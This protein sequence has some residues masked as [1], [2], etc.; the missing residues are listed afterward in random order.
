MLDVMRRSKGFT[1]II[2]GLV[3]LATAGS[4]ALAMYGLWGGGL[5]GKEQGAPDWIANVDGE[6]I[7]TIVFQ[8]TRSAIENDMRQR[9]AGQASDEALASYV[10]QQALGSVLGQYL[11]EREAE[12]AGLRVTAAEISS[13]IVNSP[14]WQKDGRFV[15]VQAYRKILEMNRIKVAEFERERQKELAAEKLRSAVYALARVDDAEVDRRFRDEVERVDV[16]YVLLADTAFADAKPAAPAEVRSWYSSHAS[17]FTTPEARR[18]VY[19]LFDRESKAASLPVSDAEIKDAYEKGKTTTYS[20]P[21]QRRASHI[22]IKVPQ[23]APPEKDAEIKAKAAALLAR[24]RAGED[25]ATLA[26]Q[27]SEDPGSAAAGGDLG[28]F[29][30]NRMVKEFEDAAFSLSVGAVSDVVKSPFGYHIIK[31]TEA[32]PAGVQPLDEVK[33]EIRRSLVVTKAQEEVRKSAEEFERKLAAQESSFDKSASALGYKLADTGYFEKGSPAGPLGRLPQVEDA[34]F[35]LKPGGVSA[36]VTVPQGLAVFSLAE[37]RA[38]RP[39]PFDNVKEKVETEL[40]KSR[41]RDKARSIAGEIVAAKGDLKGRVEKRKL[42]VKS[43]PQVTRAQSLPPLTDASK[44]AA[45]AAPIGA[46][47]GPYE[48][49]DG[50]LVIAVKGKSPATSD[51]A[52]SERASL[53]R[54]MLDEERNTLY[55]AFLSR[56]EKTSQIEINE[57]LLRRTRGQS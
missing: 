2:F 12:R 3:V 22:L 42:E 39:A 44:A 26:R 37:V 46:V 5:S 41:A 54:R 15:G 55:Q 28:F 45:F 6:P 30:R 36:P 38:P 50:L 40:K 33:A 57:G 19:I 56:V 32:R 16:E 52:V 11:S 21:D 49:D 13:D 47:L 14:T 23:D 20:H 53:R 18:A 25:F 31:V 27:N 34:V 43:L 51:E 35:S 7:P 9:F 24:V 10:D 17:R 1:K 29:G 4:L 48:T 8:K